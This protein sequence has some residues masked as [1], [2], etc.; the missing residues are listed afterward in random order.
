MAKSITE[1]GTLADLIASIINAPI[2]EKQKILDSI[3]IKTRL[4]ELTRMVNHQ[5]EV[6]ELGNKIQTKVKDD[7][8]KKASANTTCVSAQSH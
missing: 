7:I 5:K 1:A 4:K 6:L 8:D 3:D 2:E